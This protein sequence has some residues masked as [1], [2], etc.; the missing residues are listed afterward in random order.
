MQKLKAA[1]DMGRPVVPDRTGNRGFGPLLEV[2]GVGTSG[3][4]CDL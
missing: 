1:A 3:A 2:G 4:H